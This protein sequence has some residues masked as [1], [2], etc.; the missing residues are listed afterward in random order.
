MFGTAVKDLQPNGGGRG[1]GKLQEHLQR[2]LDERK[3]RQ[4]KSSSAAGKHGVLK[5]KQSNSRALPLIPAVFNNKMGGSVNNKQT[6]TIASNAL[7]KCNEYMYN[8]IHKF[9]CTCFC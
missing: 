9:S 1:G 6:T 8:T 4:R 2:R 3:V 7:G 5:F